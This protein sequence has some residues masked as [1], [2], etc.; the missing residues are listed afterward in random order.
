MWTLS[1]QIQVQRY[2]K[3]WIPG[4]PWPPLSWGPHKMWVQVLVRPVSS[5]CIWKN[6]SWLTVMH[7]FAPNFPFIMIHHAISNSYYSFI[8]ILILMLKYPSTIFL[9]IYSPAP[10]LHIYNNSI[11]F[12]TPELRLPNSTS[13]KTDRKSHQGRTFHIIGQYPPTHIYSCPKASPDQVLAPSWA[14]YHHILYAFFGK[15]IFW[16]KILTFQSASRLL[17][18]LR[19]CI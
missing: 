5:H 2:E 8:I 13:A 16:G 3:L 4:N 15:P 1:G 6:Y 7:S 14:F 19:T 10:D 11:Y 9:I 18:V 12:H 17:E